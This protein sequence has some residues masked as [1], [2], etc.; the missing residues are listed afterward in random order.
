MLDG[1]IQEGILEVLDGNNKERHTVISTDA[2]AFIIF[3]L[4]DS[5]EVQ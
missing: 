3:A 4:C 5:A 1:L 2:H